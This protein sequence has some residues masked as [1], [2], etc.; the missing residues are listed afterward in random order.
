[1][2]LDDDELERQARVLYPDDPYLQQQWLRAV[3]L[4][5]ATAHGWCLDPPP[6]PPA[7]RMVK[8]VERVSAPGAV[9]T[10]D[11]VHL[12]EA[13]EAALTTNIESIPERQAPRRG[14]GP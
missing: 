8:S 3:R 1:M 6:L 2:T 9:F 13:G 4:V 10:V 14:C 5:R 12:T 11:K 7:Q